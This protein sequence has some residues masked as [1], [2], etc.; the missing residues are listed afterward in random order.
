[1]A[2][3][4]LGVDIGATKSHALIC[5]AE[6]QAA[7]VGIGGPGNHESIGKAGFEQVLNTVTAAAL[8]QAG[9][10]SAEIAGERA[11]AWLAMTGRKMRPG[12]TRSSARWA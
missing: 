12:C 4:F 1:M 3:Y 7:G 5:D 8:A 9:I 2:D 10:T 6:G 11:L